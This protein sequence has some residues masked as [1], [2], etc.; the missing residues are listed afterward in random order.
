MACDAHSYQYLT[1]A[2][3]ACELNTFM[4]IQHKDPTH[5]I[6]VASSLNEPREVLTTQTQL[7]IASTNLP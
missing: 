1:D 5:E 7:T 4:A 3:G 6:S 2:M